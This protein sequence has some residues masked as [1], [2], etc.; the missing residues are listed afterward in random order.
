MSG[1]K[2]A[3]LTRE[4]CGFILTSLDFTRQTFRDHPYPGPNA[5]GFRQARLAEVDEVAG[6]VRAIRDAL[7]QKTD[8]RTA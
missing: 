6:K 1:G 8:R 5:Y 2:A 3:T 4:D 7:P